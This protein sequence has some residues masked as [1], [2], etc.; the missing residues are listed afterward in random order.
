MT[1]AQQR[2]RALLSLRPLPDVLILGAMRSGTTFLHNALA[3]HP[4]IAAGDIKELQFFSFRWS[5]GL[6]AYRRRLPLQWPDAV[7]ACTGLKRRLVIDSSPYYLFHPLAPQRAAQTLAPSAKMI[8]LLREPGARAWSHYRWSL[9]QGREH[10]GFLTALAA[11]EE[12]LA[13]EAE[14]IAAGQQVTSAPHQR[15]SYVARGRYAEQLER[16]WR[17][18]PR[19]RFLLLRS[20]NLYADPQTVFDG[21]CRFLHLRPMAL[22]A[23]LARNALP[24]LPLPERARDILDRAFE[25]PNQRLRE[26]TG[27]SFCQTNA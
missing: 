4:Q 2:W 26:L 9:R 25:C 15:F 23:A 19:E 8:V 14:R 22:P 16:W 1:A 27:I 17:Y 21:V 7:V 5:E 11:E 24:S 6:E 20:E 3:A 10:L 13:G 12:R 18:F